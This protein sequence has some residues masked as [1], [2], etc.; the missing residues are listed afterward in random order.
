MLRF[1][2]TV[3][4][5]KFIPN[6]NY[7]RELLE[8]FTLGTTDLDGNPNY[9]QDDIVQ[10]ARAFTGWRQTSGGKPYLDLASHDTKAEFPE[11]GDKR[12]FTQTG[13]FGPN[14]REFDDQ[15]EGPQE[16][17]RVVDHIFDHRDT[18]GRSTVARRLAARLLEYFCHGGYANPAV[19]KPV[20]TSVVAASGFDANWNVG[21]LM[22]AIL[23]HDAFYETAGAPPYSAGD[24][25]SLSWPVDYIVT[26][27]RLLGVLPRGGFSAIAGGGY[28]PIWEHSSNMGQRLFE[29]PSV[30]GWDWEESWATSATMLA[31]FG[32]ARDV[33]TARGLTSGKGRFQPDHLVDLGLT[34]G[35]DIVDAVVDACGVTGLYTAAERDVLIDYLTDGS[36]GAP[37]DLHD[38]GVRN[39]KL[40]GLFALVLRSPAYQLR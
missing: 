5:E 37:L 24:A 21:G 34:D 3:R 36:P 14:G 19:A 10:I 18:E 31:R 30:F 28:L 16:I 11:R 39:A 17:D 13:G 15:G 2:D 4:N 9:R 12:I 8:L 32:F 25:K 40:H 23:V 6:E 26:T 22:R 20:A 7:A 35:A 1:L 38:D 27:L 29:P 33:T